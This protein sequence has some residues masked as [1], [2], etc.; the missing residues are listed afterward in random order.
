MLRHNVAQP[1]SRCALSVRNV[2]YKRSRKLHT[3]SLADG[4]SPKLHEW[5]IR[6]PTLKDLL[7][8]VQPAACTSVKLRVP[9]SL[10][11]YPSGFR[12]LLCLENT[13]YII[14]DGTK[15]VPLDSSARDCTVLVDVGPS[16]LQCKRNRQDAYS[17]YR[18][19]PQENEITTRLGMTQKGQVKPRN[20]KTTS[21]GR[22]KSSKDRQ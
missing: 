1:T 3:G 4:I 12:K 22:Q 21:T 13:N 8:K 9:V 11:F 6:R 18:R 14:I 16:V 2:S 20:S 10:E 17:L 5:A 19:R 15:R 7:W